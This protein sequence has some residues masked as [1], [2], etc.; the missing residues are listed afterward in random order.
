MSAGGRVLTNDHVIDHC[1]NRIAVVRADGV[2]RPAV[3]LSS[4][5]PNDLALLKFD[6]QIVDQDIAAIRTSPPVKQGE[7]IAV[8]GFPLVGTLSSSGNI[9]NGIL[10]ALVG[11]GDDSRFMQ[12][13]APVQ[14]GNSGGPLL[15]QSANVIGVVVSKL[16]AATM[17]RRT[18]DI[19]QNVNFAIKAG[20]AIGFLEAHNVAYLA[21]A[22]PSGAKL[23]LPEIAD[24][25][26]RFTVLVVC[27]GG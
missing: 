14:P 9:T 25:A 23:E 20:V 17:M 12:L 2:F 21:S 26:R 15:D 27:Q 4:D 11:L 6:G 1:Q 5:K 8:Y 19:P 7:A 13:T 10:S 18:G 24:A 3:L 22:P 16:D